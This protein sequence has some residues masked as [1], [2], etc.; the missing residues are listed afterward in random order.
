[1]DRQRISNIKYA[2][3]TIILATALQMINNFKDL[4]WESKGYNMMIN[5]KKTKIMAVKGYTEQISIMLGNL[6]PE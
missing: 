3:D 4:V 1:M 2:N 6:I 5:A